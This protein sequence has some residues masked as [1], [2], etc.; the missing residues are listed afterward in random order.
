M[1]LT[2]EFYKTALFDLYKSYSER[3]FLKFSSKLKNTIQNT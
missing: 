2:A 1:P 3:L